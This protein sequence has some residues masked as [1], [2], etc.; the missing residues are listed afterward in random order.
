M[1]KEEQVEERVHE[2]LNEYFLTEDRDGWKTVATFGAVKKR[3]N[4]NISIAI[5]HRVHKKKLYV[6]LAQWRKNLN[7]VLKKIPGKGFHLDIESFT[8]LTDLI[9]EHASRLMI[10][11]DLKDI[12]SVMLLRSSKFAVKSINEEISDMN[13][14]ELIRDE[15]SAQG[16]D[17]DSDEA[18]YQETYNK[19]YKEGKL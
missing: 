10:K 5:R 16:I 11:G 13:E 15:I 4:D 12:N 19:L 8:F 14:L 1:I 17:P 18:N 9:K 7:G 2:D 6:E 3:T